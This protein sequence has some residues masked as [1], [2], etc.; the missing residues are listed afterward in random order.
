MMYIGAYVRSYLTDATCTAKYRT[1]YT[2]ELCIRPIVSV[3]CVIRPIWDSEVVMN[4]GRYSYVH[5]SKL[6]SSKKPIQSPKTHFCCLIKQA[7]KRFN[8]HCFATIKL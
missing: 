5:I 2:D 4:V 6:T 7:I 1:L 3:T 8:L